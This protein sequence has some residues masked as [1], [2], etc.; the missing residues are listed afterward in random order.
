MELVAKFQGVS[1]LEKFL[2][3]F[4]TGGAF[5][6]YEALPSSSKEDYAAI[7][8]ALAGAFSV[9]RFRAYEEFSKRRLRP[10]EAVDVFLTDLRSL[11]AKVSGDLSDE[12]LICAFLAGLPDDVNI[13]LKSLR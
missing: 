7:R 2:P 8:S 11:G 10:G 9:D 1:D 4:L 3:L 6:V 5:A 13:N 12:W